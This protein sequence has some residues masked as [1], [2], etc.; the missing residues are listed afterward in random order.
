MVGNKSKI[1]LSISQKLASL[2]VEG[3]IKH[4][5][6]GKL[7]ER[8]RNNGH[9]ELP[10]YLRTLLKIPRTTIFFNIHPGHY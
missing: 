9:P 7:L 2:T 1:S 4:S 10:K 5:F 3:N 6:L 8:L